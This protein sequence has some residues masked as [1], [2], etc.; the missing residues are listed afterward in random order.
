MGEPAENSGNHLYGSTTVSGQATAVLGNQHVRIE[1]ATFLVCD[2]PAIKYRPTL[3]NA[4]SDLFDKQ[5]ELSSHEDCDA[6]AADDGRA[7]ALDSLTALD[8]VGNVLQII[9]LTRL[10]VLQLKELRST[11][12]LEYVNNI[13]SQ[14]GDV[15]RQVFRVK[16]TA[17]AQDTVAG[18]EAR[19]AL[20]PLCKQ[21]IAGAKEVDRH[22][23]DVTTSLKKARS[24][25]E[26]GTVNARR[27]TNKTQLKYKLVEEHVEQLERLKDQVSLHVTEA[28]R[29]ATTEHFQTTSLKPETVRADIQAVLRLLDDRG[30]GIKQA[31]F[32]PDG[33]VWRCF[34]MSTQTR[35]DGL[36]NIDAEPPT[37]ALRT[38]MFRRCT[39]LN[40]INFRQMS[41]RIDEVEI[42]YKTTLEWIFRGEEYELA[43]SNFP[44]FLQM[45]TATH[46]YWI[47]GKAG[48]GKSTLLRFLIKH[49]K[50]RH[51]LDVWSGS[52]QLEIAHFFS[53]NLGTKLQKTQ[54]GLLQSLIHQ[55]L[56]RDQTLIH[57]VFPDLWHELDPTQDKRPDPL[58]FA[59]TKRAFA[60]LIDLSSAKRRYCFFVDGIDEFDEDHNH[61]A[62]LLLTS[63]SRNV[64][65]VLSSRPVDACV[66]K[67]GGCPQLRLQDLTSKDIELYIDGRLSSNH[68]MLDLMNEEPV[69]ARELVHALKVR[70][71]ALPPDLSKLFESMLSKM[72]PMY[73]AQAATLFRLVRTATSVLNG[74][75]MPT[76]F[77]AV[78]YRDFQSVQNGRPVSFD[79]KKIVAWCTILGRQ[80]QSRCCGLLELYVST[81]RPDWWDADLDQLKQDDRLKLSSHVQYLHRTVAEYLYQDEVWQNVISRASHEAEFDPNENLAYAALHM[82]KISPLADEL[83]ELPAYA[84]A[85][86]LIRFV[87]E[88]ERNDGP[89]LVDLID[90]MN[91]VLCHQMPTSAY[92]ASEMEVEPDHSLA[93]GHLTVLQRPVTSTL[94][95]MALAGLWACLDAKLDKQELGFAEE[96]SQRLMLQAFFS[97]SDQLPDVRF[98]DRVE[99][100]CVLLEHGANPSEAFEGLSFWQCV[101]Q[102]LAI[103]GCRLKESDAHGLLTRRRRGQRKVS[104][105]SSPSRERQ[106]GLCCCDAEQLQLWVQLIV[107]CLSAGARFDDIDV[108]ASCMSRVGFKEH[109]TY[110]QVRHILCQTKFESTEA[111]PAVVEPST[112][113]RLESTQRTLLAQFSKDIKSIL[114]TSP[115]MKKRSSAGDRPYARLTEQEREAT[116]MW[117]W[118]AQPDKQGQV[119]PQYFPDRECGNRQCGTHTTYEW[120]FVPAIQ[121]ILCADCYEWWQTKGGFRTA[122]KGKEPLLK[123]EDL[124]DESSVMVQGLDLDQILTDSEAEVETDTTVCRRSSQHFSID[125]PS[126]PGPSRTLDSADNV[127]L[128]ASQPVSINTKRPSLKVRQ[129]L[130][131]I[132]SGTPHYLRSRSVSGWE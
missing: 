105:G 76:Q 111:E 27:A 64:K 26:P 54:Q 84:W 5:K 116:D 50:T 20:V 30:A 101:L 100:V 127:Q 80:L 106:S 129:D 109:C 12:N 1:N 87:R 79:T 117:H 118:R 14:V 130:E 19:K 96:S 124:F 112:H 85:Q 103:V 126:S 41:D 35:L 16:A 93:I 32:D 53:W 98:A 119:L 69:Q 17:E 82:M 70:L 67:L 71:Q 61:V 7:V 81:Y 2:V 92:W 44:S 65:F 91:L 86:G 21:C 6:I 63:C 104:A 125:T 3:P 29:H 68:A 57:Q 40:L 43:W 99:V 90:E 45:D 59:E 132:T 48:S 128:S 83:A 75:S 18:A 25:R 34:D 33:T 42:A 122:P 95:L 24:K 131:V 123:G 49:E 8:L 102:Q 121:N 110:V 74:E 47:N 77:L 73:Q 4:T 52:Q 72:D 23:E 107:A 51:H 58:T 28:L 31:D 108:L 9:H 94:S 113:V 78:A 46:P 39:I 37:S 11:G 62:D 56:R 120:R 36:H 38:T 115:V 89:I 15:K 10:L 114:E 97:R 13:R 55:I 66:E 22:L 60:R 88:V